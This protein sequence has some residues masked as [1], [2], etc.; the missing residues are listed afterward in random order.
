MLVPSRTVINVSTIPM[1]VDGFY[2]SRVATGQPA[3]LDLTGWHKNLIKPATHQH[4]PK[5]LGFFWGDCW[6]FFF[7]DHICFNPISFYQDRHMLYWLKP[8]MHHLVI[9]WTLF[10]FFFREMFLLCWSQQSGKIQKLN[11]PTG[12]A[13]GLILVPK[14]GWWF[15]ILFIFTPIW[16]RWTH[17]DEH[18]FQLGWNHQLEM[19]ALP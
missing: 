13:I 10:V 18:I 7:N 9:V 19:L 4:L 15:Q 16:G 12:H 5:I 11:S 3:G 17:F 6:V 14:S 8:F 2:P 1:D